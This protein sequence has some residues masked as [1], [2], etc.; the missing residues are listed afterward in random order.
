RM[1]EQP[2]RALSWALISISGDAV[3]DITETPNQVAVDSEEQLAPLVGFVSAGLGNGIAQLQGHRSSLTQ[4]EAAREPSGHSHDRIVVLATQSHDETSA[5]I[6][7]ARIVRRRS[8]AEQVVRVGKAI[9]PQVEV[10]I[11]QRPAWALTG[12]HVDIVEIEIARFENDADSVSSRGNGDLTHRAVF[13]V[14]PTRAGRHDRTGHVLPV[15]FHAQ[16]P[17]CL[18]TCHTQYEVESRS[19]VDVNVV[20]EPFPR[21]GPTHVATATKI[22]RLLAIDR[23]RAAVALIGRV[24][25]E[26]ALEVFRLDPGGEIFE[27]PLCALARRTFRFAATCRQKQ[28]C[29]SYQEKWTRLFGSGQPRE[30]LNVVAIHSILRPTHAFGVGKQTRVVKLLDNGNQ[31][32]SNLPDYPQIVMGAFDH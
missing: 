1:E 20:L 7:T 14:L 13:E 19:L 9:R 11:D 28:C 10:R 15:D 26:E 2:S 25:V 5:L 17:S 30:I 16:G 31:L 21:S 24:R 23:P 4:G 8:A 3:D 6:G 32:F 22:L 18:G 12:Q 29:C 27:E